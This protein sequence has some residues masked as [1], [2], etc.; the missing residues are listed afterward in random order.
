MTD[1]RCIDCGLHVF[2]CECACQEC[3]EF[4]C[5]SGHRP[6]EQPIYTAFDESQVRSVDAV[7]LAT[8]L[9]FGMARCQCTSKMCESCKQCVA[10]EHNFVP[11]NWREMVWLVVPLESR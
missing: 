1:E 8:Q 10:I 5:A 9:P 6:D 4:Q 7:K 2:D 11:H 3:G